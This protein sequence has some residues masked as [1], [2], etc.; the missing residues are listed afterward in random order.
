M[1]T[2]FLLSD[3]EAETLQRALAIYTSEVRNEISHTDDL[4]YR[5]GLQEE[6][7]CLKSIEDRLSGYISIEDRKAG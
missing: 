6:F 5:A 2:K 7:D 1:K 3:Q 4:N